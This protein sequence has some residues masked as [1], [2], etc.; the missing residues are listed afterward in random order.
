MTVFLQSWMTYL[1][2]TLLLE[3]KP[4]VISTLIRNCSNSLIIHKENTK[5][6]NV[7]WVFGNQTKNYSFFHP[8]FFLLK[9]F[10]LIK[11][12]KNSTQCFITR[13]NTSKFVQ[14]TPLRVLFS[15]LISVFRLVM[16]HCVSCLISYINKPEDDYR[17]GC[18]SVSHCQQQQSYSGLRSPGRSNSTYFWDDSW[19]WVQTFHR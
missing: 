10:C 16:K 4:S 17:T 14:N 1:E 19:P 2:Q 8:W 11:N 3:S 6:I 5:E 9:S 7:S 18:R 15:T 13:W 12:I